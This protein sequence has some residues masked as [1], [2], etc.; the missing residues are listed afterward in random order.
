MK[1]PSGLG[2]C[3]RWHLQ[4]EVSSS[5]DHCGGGF[6]GGHRAFEIEMTGKVAIV[7]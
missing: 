3:W 7:W 5:Q 1:D 6:G 2:N 4:E